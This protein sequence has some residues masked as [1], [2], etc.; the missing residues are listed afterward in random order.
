MAL[1]RF[2]SVF[3]WVNVLGWGLFG[4]S[5]TPQTNRKGWKQG[6]RSGSVFESYKPSTYF[7]CCIATQSYLIFQIMILFQ[8]SILMKARKSNLPCAHDSAVPWPGCELG[9]YF[10]SCGIYDWA[11]VS[12][13][14]W[15][16]NRFVRPWAASSLVAPSD[17]LCPVPGRQA[18]MDS[19][20]APW[21][22][23]CGKISR[24]FFSL[25]PPSPGC[26]LEMVLVSSVE[27]HSSYQVAL[28]CCRSW[29]LAA[30]TPS[31]CSFRPR[32]GDGSLLL[33]APGYPTIL[34][35][36]P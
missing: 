27:S 14:A 12:M 13:S 33:L 35:S 4:A 11:G 16:H 17:L 36:V 2:K 1:I 6:W 8:N 28:S 24:Y 15:A 10:L 21:P 23:G 19:L 5:H 18:V 22:S 25:L 29:I 9:G 30:S 34:A 26:G 31:S 32:G 7:L 3:F 20:W